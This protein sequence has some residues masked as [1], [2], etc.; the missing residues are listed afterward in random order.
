M[1]KVRSDSFN[2]DMLLRE[3]GLLLLDIAVIIFSMT[4]A[5][6]IRHDFHLL[7]IE[8]TFFDT[9]RSYLFVNLIC[10][11]LIFAIMKLYSSLWRFASI[12]ELKN[13]ILATI[14]STLL[15]CMGMWY[16]DLPIPRSYPFLYLLLLTGLTIATRFSYRFGRIALHNYQNSRNEEP[17]RTMIIGAGAAGYMIVREMKNS[18]H[19]NRKIPCIIDDDPSKTGTYL[20]GI[21][22]VGKKEKIPYFAD[23]YHIEEIVI[24]I[25][26]ISS[27]AQ[28]ELLEICQKTACKVLILPGI[29]QLVNEDVSVSMLRE[30]E[31]EDLLGRE[32]VNLKTE[33][34]MDYVSGKVILVTGG[35]GSIG[36]EICR[37]LALYNPKQLIIFD[38]YEN[39]AYEIQNELLQNHPDLNLLVLIGSVRNQK[40]V[41]SVFEQ[42]HPDL[43]YH[44]AAHKHVPLMETSPNEAVKNNV[45]GTWVVAN[46]ADRFGAKKM[47]LISTDKAVRPTNI[48]GA[49]KR[50]CELIVQSFAQRSRTEYAAVRFGN[51]L[52]SNGSVIPLFRKQI[53]KGGP[54]TVTHPEIIRYFMTIP[55]AVNLV[56]QCG[57]LAQGGEIFILDM[58]EPVKI[59]D[60]AKNMIRLSGFVP[61]RDIEIVFTG[62]RP[63]EKLYE[64]LL[65]NED[66]LKKTEKDRIFVVQQTHV[67]D[68][69]IQEK[70]QSMVQRAFEEDCDIRHLVQELVPEYVIKEEALRQVAAT[71]E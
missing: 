58:G 36:S 23:K 33:E 26:T 70:V 43:V 5:L 34:V 27:Q 15:Q 21:P 20:Q 52:G 25:P 38:I 35:G 69:W 71:R 17:V 66:N 53:A 14:L 1:K 29:Y 50:I 41:D 11:V 44:A 16:M 49:S 9:I 65:I 59:L 62:L 68:E 40:R 4:G 63:G 56:L 57:A 51:V 18:K 24:A 64:E 3:A 31:I 28:K 6:W 19:L 10:T 32:P 7:D 42:Y 2:K 55:E 60:L 22:I 47:V 67:E 37:Q 54:V 8:P 12:V 30:V 39:N 48:M 13:V 46:A 45:L 61:D